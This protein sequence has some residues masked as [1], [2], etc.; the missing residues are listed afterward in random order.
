MILLK[1]SSWVIDPRLQEGIKASNHINRLNS[2]VNYNSI[3]GILYIAQHRAKK[4]YTYSESIEKFYLIYF[5]K[6]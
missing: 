4:Y 5:I 1:D 2:T 3:I 6:V